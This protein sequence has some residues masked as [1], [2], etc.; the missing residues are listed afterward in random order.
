MAHYTFVDRVIMCKIHEVP[1]ILFGTSP[2]LS[3]G[4]PA[5][6]KLIR[7]RIRMER[8]RARHRKKGTK[9]KRH[10]HE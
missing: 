3:R 6:V 5:C 10:E 9:E 2:N 8:A 4:C 7:D 1:F